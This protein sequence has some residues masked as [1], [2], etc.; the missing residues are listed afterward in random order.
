MGLSIVRL[1][2][3]IAA[4]VVVQEQYER[5]CTKPKFHLQ[6]WLRRLL[7]TVDY[8][9]V[10]AMTYSKVAVTVTSN[11]VYRV[12]IERFIDRFAYA[13]EV[14]PET[15]SVD[16]EYKELDVW[17]S[18]NTLSVIAM[19]DADFD[20][21]ISGKDVESTR[22]IGELWQRVEAKLGKS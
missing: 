20:V 18:L 1:S 3:R 14:E 12:S 19:A 2:R 9:H 4:L 5:L 10:P 6:E 13:I 15:L 22:T 16:T 8:L 21:A 17:D 7:E 11:G